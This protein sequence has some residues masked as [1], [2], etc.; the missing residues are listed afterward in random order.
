V[1]DPHVDVL[2]YQFISIE[3][4]NDFTAATPWSG[5]LGDFECR[6]EAWSLEAIPNKHFASEASARQELEP[7]LRAWE[8]W[9]ELQDELRLSFRFSS[10]RVVDRQPGAGS[11]TVAVA[12]AEAAGA[13]ETATVIKGH[14]S[15]PAPSA[16]PLATSPL[17]S[18]LLGW[19]RDLRAGHRMLVIAYLILTRLEFEYGDRRSAASALNVEPLVLSTLGRLSVKNDP[20]ERRKVKGVA[21]PLTEPEKQWIRAVL[22]RLALQAATAAAGAQPSRLTMADLPSL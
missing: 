2:N 15:Y 9:A 22:P 6:L 14:S 1:N 11:V 8:L 13:V 7:H 18:E 20:A 3:E 10:A 21:N 12:A 19:V 4:N 17:V 5:R 16:G